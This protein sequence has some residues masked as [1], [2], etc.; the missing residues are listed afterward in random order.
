MK[1][2]RTLER[3][4]TSA[5]DQVRV[6]LITEVERDQWNALVDDKHYLSSHLVGPTLRYVAEL[7]GE[8]VGLLSF[9]QGSYHLREREA[10][11]GW[12]EVQRGRRLC[13]VGQN[14]RFVLLHERG[15][16]PNLASRVLSLGCNRVSSDWEARFGNPLV[17][18]ETFVDAERFSGGCYLAAG[19]QRLGQTAGYGR[20]RKDFYQLHDRPKDLWFKVLDRRGF[21]SLSSGR[22][23]PRLKGY[24]TEWRVCPFKAPAMESLFESFADVPEHR[25]R[26]GRR[27]RLQTLLSVIALATLCG[28]SGHRAIAS[29]ASKLTDAQR[30]RLRCPRNRRTQQYDVPKET[31]IREVLYEL[32]AEGLENVLARWMEGLD[33]SELRYIAIDGKTLKGTARRNEAGEKKGA[34]H[35]VSAVEHSSCRLIAQQAVQSKSNEIPAVQELIRRIPHLEGAV[36]TTDALSCQQE[37]AR[38]IVQEKGGPTT[39]GSGTTNRACERRQSRCSAPA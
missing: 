23:P 22:L 5:L 37:T 2:T 28:F 19:W 7:D 34:L 6:R 32:D 36:I 1:R 27:Y 18:V 24:E 29:F 35:L 17:A 20:R 4:E 12:S 31:C 11:I 39:S 8:W 25:G 14:T 26:R 9:G 38:L 13:L 15:E 16:Y 10:H 21:R 3:T 30:R 33:E